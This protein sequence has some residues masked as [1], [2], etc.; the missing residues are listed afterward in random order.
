MIL[1]TYGKTAF[2]DGVCREQFRHF[3][4]FAAEG[5]HSGQEKV[6]EDA[7]LEAILNKDPY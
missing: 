6:V 1:D 3:K 4:N 7:Q 2:N 5:R